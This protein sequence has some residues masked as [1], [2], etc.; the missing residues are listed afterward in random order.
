[1]GEK[2][3]FLTLALLSMFLGAVAA[4]IT[5]AAGYP[6]GPLE[7]IC[8]YAPGS[9]TDLALRVIADSGSKHF[10]QPMV[11]INKPGAGGALA[12]ADVI[13]SR[14]DGYKAF[15][16][17]QVFFATTTKTQK[18]P[19]N[20]DDLVPLANF[21]EL[22]MGMVVKGDSP[23]KTFD[24]LLDYAKKSQG[25]FKWAHVGRGITLHMSGLLI[26]KRAGVTTIDVPY[27]GTPE[28]LVALLGGHV[29]AGSLAYGA[30]SEQVKA[31]KARY[32]MFYA[33]KRFKDQPGVP[34]A[35]ELGFPEAVLPTFFGLYVHKDTS[36]PIKKTL[37]EVCKKISE[38][39]ETRKGIE[40]LGEEPRFGG[41]EFMREAIKKQEAIGVPIL[42]EIGLYVGK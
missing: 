16:G 22:K 4:D 3:V 8:P 2:A 12:A 31:G 25:Q 27:K 17:A 23:F 20:P 24:D 13:S 30:V 33:D 37:A 32:L 41:P 14:P 28:A 1:M 7:I 29:D 21:V 26:F 9:T 35:V 6:A 40:R 38:D 36:E 10:G 39:P 18:V 11:V 19:F 34:T 5:Q 15:W 42:K